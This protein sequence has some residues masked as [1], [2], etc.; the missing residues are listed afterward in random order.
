MV[1]GASHVRGICRS[2][3]AFPSLQDFH[4]PGMGRTERLHARK[5][6]LCGL[7][8]LKTCFQE[9]ADDELCPRKEFLPRGKKNNSTLLTV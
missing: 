7:S 4:I 5:S 2:T 9:C 3:V 6:G 8:V 1:S